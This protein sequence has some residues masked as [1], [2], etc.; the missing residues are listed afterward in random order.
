VPDH[1]QSAY[2]ER[3]SAHA[4]PPVPPGGVRPGQLG[5]LMTGRVIIGDIAATLVDLS[6]RGLLQVEESTA[7]DTQGWVLTRAEPHG[8]G[9][10]LLKY[11]EVLLDWL[12]RPGYSV[13]LAALAD[14]L[15]T[16][17]D[18]ARTCLIRDGVHRGWLR[19]LH[20]GER[21]EAA[22]E[23]AGQIRAFQR[24]L[25]HLKVTGA[26]VE[27]DLLAYAL[28]FGMADPG[29]PLVRFAHDWAGIFGDLPGWR[30]PAPH[31][32][33][34]DH[35]AVPGPAVSKP[36]IDEQMLSPGVGAMIW[37]SGFGV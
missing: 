27:D 33:A 14:D 15:P 12:P 5:V 30:E 25:R 1:D 18:E 23:L 19:H 26:A 20:H 13:S 28:H 9:Q 10:P 16:G 22:H 6:V 34:A 17:L 31:S 37:V 24:S 11:E 8:G 4:E 3:V 35:A 21:T 36:T 32:T 2:R 7:G 29:L